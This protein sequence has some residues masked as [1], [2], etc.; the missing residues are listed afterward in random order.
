MQ[1]TQRQL[2]TAITICLSAGI[3][4]A[5]GVSRESAER[6][7]LV[8]YPYITCD[9]TPGFQMSILDWFLVCAA[10]PTG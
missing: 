3:R 4:Q 6:V 10:R 5:K 8:T 1:T 2:E 7:W 9:R